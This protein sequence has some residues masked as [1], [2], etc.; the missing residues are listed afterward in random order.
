MQVIYTAHGFHFF[1][2]AP[3]INWLIYYPIEK[4]LSKYTD[5]L[6]TINKEDYELAINKKFKA[7][8]IYKI[9]GVGVDAGKFNIQLSNDDKKNLRKELSSIG[10]DFKI[11][12][13]D[14]VIT[15]V[16]EL[17]PRKNQEMLIE[18]IHDIIRNG[19]QRVPDENQEN[20]RSGALCAPQNIKVLLVGTGILKD[21]YEK[22]IKEYN[23]QQNILL[24]GYRRDVPQIL[25]ITNIVVSCAKQEGLPFN[26]VEAQM[27]GLPCVAT[28]CRG[29]N[30]VIEE[31]K[32]GYLIS[33]KDKKKA[34]EKFE[35][36]L[37]KLCNSQSMRERM[38]KNALENSK[39][40]KL[41]KIIDEM[42]KIYE[43]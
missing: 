23:L 31:N 35:N 32:T 30:E 28:N 15:Y 6:I 42:K 36:K 24:T 4:W 19:L 18:V 22:K 3:L 2:G 14:I 11:K 29:N 9:N 43:E 17:I 5:K 38:G 20:T 26:L 16:A 10:K 25:K 37:L 27:S 1:K 33:I 8:K 13:K 39:K 41:S 12:E 21:K 34:I 7:K 40:Y